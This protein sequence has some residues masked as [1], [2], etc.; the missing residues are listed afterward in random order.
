MPGSKPPWKPAYLSMRRGT[1]RAACALVK[2]SL[3]A[4]RAT[5]WP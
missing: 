4:A 2:I 1:C 5:V 3:T